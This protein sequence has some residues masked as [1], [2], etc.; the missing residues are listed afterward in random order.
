MRR[1]IPYELVLA[2]IAVVAVTLVY[3]MVARSEI[4]RAGGLMG[5][6]LGLLGFVLMLSSE[7]LYPLRK[8]L[9]GFTLW[10]TRRWLQIHIFTG[11]VGPFLVLLHSGGRFHGLAGVVSLLTV[12]IVI[13]GFV[14]RFIYTAVPRNLEGVELGL[15]ELQDQAERV[16]RQLQTLGWSWD[17]ALPSLI[18][19]TAPGGWY[20]VVARHALVWRYGR[21]LRQALSPW[22]DADY[23]AAAQLHQL[24]TERYRLLLQVN[25]LATTRRLLAVW[26]MLHVPLGAVLFTLAFVH[27]GGALYYSTF[28]K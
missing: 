6:S 8:H 7:T 4:P 16:H 19:E 24:L 12:V 18:A 23:A 15:K 27:V 22:S 14:G 11:I 17:T 20:G 28:L 3:A 9:R 26:H 2:L 10:P 13:S 1:R 25:T 5:H 21:R